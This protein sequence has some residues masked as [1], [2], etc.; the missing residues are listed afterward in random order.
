MTSH[1]LKFIGI[2]QASAE[3][4]SGEETNW[5][6]RCRRVDSLLLSPSASL[7]PRPPFIQSQIHM[8]LTV[9]LLLLLFLTFPLSLSFS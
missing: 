6:W 4:D 5:S 9:E 3:G 1:K 2:V 7:F 8:I